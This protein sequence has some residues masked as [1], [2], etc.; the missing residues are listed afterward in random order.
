MGFSLKTLKETGTNKKE[1]SFLTSVD[2]YIEENYGEIRT[3]FNKDNAQ[4]LLTEIARK[5]RMIYVYGYDTIEDITHSIKVK[6]YSVY[7]GRDGEEIETGNYGT[8]HLSLYRY[9]HDEYPTEKTLFYVNDEIAYQ[10]YL[11]DVE[12]ATEKER[13]AQ[14]LENVEKQEANIKAKLEAAAKYSI[15]PEKVNLNTISVF[16]SLFS[17]TTT[18]AEKFAAFQKLE[19]SNNMNYYA[20]KHY[21]DNRIQDAVDN[22]DI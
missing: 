16:E 21:V 19:V 5:H 1:F 8:F 17:D 20:S 15:D 9:S 12:I 10:Q 18:D 7:K 11:S 4:E 14:E 6:S 13:L 2:S 3:M 22:L